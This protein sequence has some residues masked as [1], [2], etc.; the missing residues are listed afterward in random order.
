MTVTS[1][2]SLKIFWCI[3]S[4]CTF[5][6]SHNARFHEH[7]VSDYWSLPYLCTCSSTD[8]GEFSF[9][10]A[11]R[12][13]EWRSVSIM[14]IKYFLCVLVCIVCSFVHSPCRSCQWNRLEGAQFIHSYLRFQSRSNIFHKVP[15]VLR[16]WNLMKVHLR[17]S[18]FCLYRRKKKKI[19]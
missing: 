18:P 13:S 15:L 2:T 10:D 7:E 5:T 9:K 11:R 19:S 16:S 4:C 14:L 17:K 3:W 6:D 8:Q 12:I 1:A